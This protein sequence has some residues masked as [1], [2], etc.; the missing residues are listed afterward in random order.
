MPA[1]YRASEVL[2][3][4]HFGILS[5]TSLKAE[6]LATT[7]T[8]KLTEGLVTNE[9]YAEKRRMSKF[10]NASSAAYSRNATETGDVF[11][12][13][14]VDI[15]EDGFPLAHV[16]EQVIRDGKNGKIPTGTVPY[17]DA[18]LPATALEEQS[19]GQSL[20]RKLIEELRAAQEQEWVSPLR[21]L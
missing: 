13:S 15:S 3:T 5:A 17:R 18:V 9:D 6:R 14:D 16:L 2:K 20:P 21:Q 8:G 7:R 19:P 12:S 10:S 11:R 4:F 1:G